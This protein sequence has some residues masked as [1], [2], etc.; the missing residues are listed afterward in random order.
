MDGLLDNNMLA[1]PFS[2]ST[3]EV[4]HEILVHK[5]PFDIARDFGSYFL[6][7]RDCMS[8]KIRVL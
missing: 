3:R 7:Y 5:S 1:F 4:D 6:A 2:N 8:Q